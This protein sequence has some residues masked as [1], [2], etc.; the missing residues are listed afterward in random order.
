[1]KKFLTIYVFSVLAVSCA[2][3]ADFNQLV[4]RKGITYEVNSREPFDGAA[5]EKAENGQ[6]IRSGAFKDGMKDGLFEEF[7][8]NGQLRSSV[9]FFMGEK[10]GVEKIFLKNGI[11]R[12]VN[13]YEEGAL[14][15]LIESFHNNG[16]LHEKVRYEDGERVALVLAYDSD[17]TEMLELRY[18]GDEY[19]EVSEL[20]PLLEE[21]DEDEF[22]IYRRA[23]TGELFTGK[24][25]TYYPGGELESYWY[26]ENGVSQGKSEW[27]HENGQLE[28]RQNYVDGLKQGL[29]ES[30]FEDGTLQSQV[31]FVDGKVHGLWTQWMTSG[32]KLEQPYKEGKRHGVA[33]R[34]RPDGTVWRRE[35]YQFGEKVDLSVCESE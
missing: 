10:E 15:G 28:S 32:I 24:G 20:S 35:C 23:S 18:E 25:V 31:N 29:E 13:R 6:I 3:E 26:V 12:S 34:I 27:F 14:N 33:K 8:S 19:E 2:Q 22:P 30:W 1:M 17:G 11:P 16:Q 4:E 5:S 7:H 9:N 21:V